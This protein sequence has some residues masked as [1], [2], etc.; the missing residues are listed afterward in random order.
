M[1]ASLDF[2]DEDIAPDEGQAVLGRLKSVDEKISSLLATA[3]HGRVVREGV[4][5][6]IYG[7][8][9]AGKS[10][11]LN[12]L[13]GYDRAIVSASPGTTRD[14]VEE[15][16]QLNGILLRLRD[17]AGIRESAD[18]VEREGIERTKH[19]LAQADL[20]LHVIDSSQARPSGFPLSQPELAT[21]L[22]LNKSDLP[23]HADWRGE[24]GVRIS[25]KTG[26]GISALEAEILARAGGAK[27]E[28]E[29]AVA[30]NARHRDCLRRA[31]EA[32]HAAVA[33]IQNGSTPDLYA[34]DIRRALDA[35][36]ELIGTVDY[37]QILD[38]VFGQ[39]CIGK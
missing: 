3:N 1:E 18:E 4:R 33:A 37:E 30:I 15:S 22:V 27:L 21:V 34:M 17:T 26:E 11:L 38:S 31:L 32:C 9:N 5:T 14:M 8:T 12:R 39:F 6:V 35:V 13:L 10:S 29:S 19:S 24:S 23:G 7:P 25:C 20:A 36:G 28:A 16:V 2:A